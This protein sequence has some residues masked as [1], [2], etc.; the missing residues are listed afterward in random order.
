MWK[1]TSH[2]G[3]T[4]PGLVVLGS[5]RKQDEHAMRSKPVSRTSLGPEHQSC[6]QEPALFEFLLWFLQC[7]TTLW[8]YKPNKLF[9]PQIALFM[10]FHRSNCNPILQSFLK[11]HAPQNLET[12]GICPETFYI[13]TDA[14]L[15][16]GR[17]GK[18]L[19]F[20]LTLKACTSCLTGKTAQ[21]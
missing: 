13:G 5:I 11:S 21:R 12:T 17:K 1:G 18:V 19:E 16:L 15:S 4:I 10:V 9:P 14:K 3:S 8:K 6:L 2:V 20:H 7:W